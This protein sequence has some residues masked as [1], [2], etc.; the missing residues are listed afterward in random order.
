[1]YGPPRFFFFCSFFYRPEGGLLYSRSLVCVARLVVSFPGCV[2]VRCVWGV[3][4]AEAQLQ[5]S[6]DM[7]KHQKDMVRRVE[8]PFASFMRWLSLGFWL[9]LLLLLLLLLFLRMV[10]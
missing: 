4:Q 6:L 1:M 3:R 5:I 9:L 7:V 8:L 10:V 2:R